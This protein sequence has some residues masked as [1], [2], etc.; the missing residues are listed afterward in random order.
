MS[1][2]PVDFEAI[3]REQVPEL[4]AHVDNFA[5]IEV[6]PTTSAC[7]RCGVTVA[8]VDVHRQWHRN[9]TFALRVAGLM[10]SA[11]LQ[12][13]ALIATVGETGGEDAL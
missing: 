1:D 8:D 12:G 10:G 4:L 6:D 13:I 11:A 5:D 2:Q 7:L 3:L 9:I